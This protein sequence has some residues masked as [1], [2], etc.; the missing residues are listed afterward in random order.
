MN[1]AG[2][3]AGSTE[4]LGGDT[5]ITVAPGA[6][7]ILRD[8]TI[9][10]AIGTGLV[11]HGTLTVRRSTISA[12]DGVD[13]E[14]GGVLNTATLTLYAVIISN[15]QGEEAGAL[16]NHGSAVIAAAASSTTTPISTPG[17]PQL[18]QRHLP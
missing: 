6:D 3:G 12:N 1:L 15:N 10:G 18:R 7:V 14:A 5:G 16:E 17:D 4:I 9:T 8:L 13:V 2:A 11:N